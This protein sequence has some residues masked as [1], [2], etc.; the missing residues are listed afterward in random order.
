M[1]SENS[2]EKKRGMF[3]PLLIWIIVVFLVVV[4]TATALALQNPDKRDWYFLALHDLK[5]GQE[6]EAIK[7]LK[8]GLK[9]KD[10]FLA[11][12]ALEELTFLGKDNTRLEYATLLHETYKDQGSLQR[13]TDE[14]LRN[15]KYAE[16]IALTQD[17]PSDAPDALFSNRLSAL[18]IS[19]D[20]NFSTE[21][22]NWF[23]L[24]PISEDHIHF[25]DIFNI[26]TESLLGNVSHKL[27]DLRIKIYYRDYGRAFTLAQEIIGTQHAPHEWLAAQPAQILSD[28]GKA[29]LY[30]TDNHVEI[31][32]FLD[33]TIE[34]LDSTNKT[35]AFYLNFYAGRL[36]DRTSL[37]NRE[38]TFAHYLTAMKAAPTEA[39]Y[40]NALWYYFS[41]SL[42]QSLQ[43]AQDALEKYVSTIHDP[44]YYSDFFD[45]LAISCFANKN[46]KTFF[47]CFEYIK[48]YADKE[49]LSR[50]AYLNGR[51]LQLDYLTPSFVGREDKDAFV[52]ELFQQAYEPGGDFYYRL[53]ATKQLNLSQTELEASFYQVD[54]LTDFFPDEN[55]EKLLLGYVQY[56][57]PE[58]IYPL[59]ESMYSGVS[60]STEKEIAY[61]LSLLGSAQNSPETGFSEQDSLELSSLDYFLQSIR[62]ASRGLYHADKQ[63]SREYFRLAYPRHFQQNVYHAI[64]QYKLPEYLIYALIRSESFFDPS[65]SSYAGAIGLTQL[66]P[67]TAGDIAKKLKTE[68]YDLTE[69]ATNITFGVFYLEELIGRLD[70]SVIDAL[71]AYNAGINKVRSWKKLYTGFPPDLF[72]EM[73]PFS[74]TRGYGKKIVSAAAI[75][76][77]LYYGKSLM[78]VLDE[79]MPF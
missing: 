46:W 20:E 28:F 52:K 39:N 51:L 63:P 53:L 72:L 22:E 8:K 23:F 16:V 7:K 40:D 69:P 59:W 79:V 66:M 64:K 77:N 1:D 27:I 32:E 14:L 42:E 41:A 70:N 4:G 57:L 2:V 74:E 6:Q 38:K 56:N 33:S 47:T 11:R 25:T 3:S 68:N 76:G 35:A 5:T 55:T 29:F 61:A 78:G 50:Y 45:T 19:G 44:F 21:I 60:I 15:K 65:I 13:Y 54:L 43:A 62:L 36:Y 31:A 9:S 73:I 75:Y 71:Y 48:D 30:G 10:D 17:I 18:A 12:K 58:K 24:R 34:K 37:K 49:T 26:T 67:L